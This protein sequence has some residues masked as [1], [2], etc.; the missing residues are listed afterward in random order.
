MPITEPLLDSAD[1]SE[2]ADEDAD[3]SVAE[4]LPALTVATLPPNAL[5]VPRE[6][7]GTGVTRVEPE[8]EV[9]VRAP[10][11][12]AGSEE[13]VKAAVEGGM[14]ERRKREVKRVGV[15]ILRVFRWTSCS[16]RLRLVGMI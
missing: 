12:R 14:V 7:C 1:P 11:P 10:E 6:D 3:V 8:T 4:V 9:V 15:Y 13:A 5:I 2:D 16:W